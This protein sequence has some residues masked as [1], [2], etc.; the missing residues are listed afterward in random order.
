MAAPKSWQAPPTPAHDAF[1]NSSPGNWASS[2]DPRSPLDWKRAHIELVELSRKSAKLDAEIGRWLL[3][4]ARAATPACLGYASVRE[5]AEH[6]FGFTPR[7]TQERL[8]VAE[9]VE[10]LPTLRLALELGELPWSVVRELTRVATAQTAAEWLKAAHNRTAR[11]VEQMVRGH[12]P[13]DHPGDPVD[14]QLIPK[15]LRFELSPEVY[16]TVQEA[17]GKLRRAAGERIDDEQALL[18]MARQVLAGPKDEGRSSYQI[19]ISMCPSCRRG[20]QQARGELVELSREALE[21]ACCDAQHIG[22]VDSDACSEEAA[23]EHGPQA[24]SNVVCASTLAESGGAR[25]TIAGQR[26]VDNSTHVSKHLAA[27]QPGMGSNSRKPRASQSIPP[28]FRREVM[29]QARGCCEVAGC[30]N[31]LFIDVHHC[32]LRSEGGQHD[33]NRMVAACGAHHR[34]VH[35]GRLVIEGDATS[36]WKFRHADGTSYGAAVSAPEAEACTKVFAALRRLG[37]KESACRRALEQVRRDRQTHASA[38]GAEA[39]LAVEQWLRAALAVLT[40][41]RRRR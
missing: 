31:D 30:S 25:G 21:T 14:T 24:P 3:Y 38:A 13:G 34:A 5:Y 33:P 28:R 35:S 16:A 32:D 10:E 15:V 26:P 12:R 6:L 17:L 9:A 20:F 8:R 39:K 2:V 4:A 37:F 23:A 40:P 36:G 41:E 18:L 11:Q 22:D 19:A 1:S 29:R 27:T 7:Q